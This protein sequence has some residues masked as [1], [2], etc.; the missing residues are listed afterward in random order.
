ME[1]GIFAGCTVSAILFLAAFNILIKFVF[2]EKFPL[3]R[4]ANGIR[5][6]LLHGF[7]D[8]LTVMTTRVP[9]ARKILEL[10]QVVLLWARMKPNASK[11]R[12]CVI[13][14]GQCMDVE[15]FEMGGETI[16]SL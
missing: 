2:A 8:D 10:M 14:K 6:P 11:A 12:S 1:K 9:H 3:F 5:L 15:P 16:P 4:L 13:V 7:M